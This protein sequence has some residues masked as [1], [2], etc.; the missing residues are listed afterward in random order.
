MKYNTCPFCKKQISWNQR[1]RFVKG[2]FLIGLRRPAPCPHCGT[3]LM[4]KKWPHRISNITSILLIVWLIANKLIG[5]LE[6]VLWVLWVLLILLIP[7]GFKT[8][9]EKT[10]EE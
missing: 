7:L 9:F 3:M 8:G 10:G 6:W 4:Y 1:H 2:V 5:G